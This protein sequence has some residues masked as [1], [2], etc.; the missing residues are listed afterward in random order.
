MSIYSNSNTMIVELENEMASVF[1]N[2][3]IEL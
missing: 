3:Q 1:L 2:D